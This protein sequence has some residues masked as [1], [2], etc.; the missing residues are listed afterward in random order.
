MDAF[1]DVVRWAD[2]EGVS[3]T[4]IAELAGVS[5]QTV[6]SMLRKETR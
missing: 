3:K 4:E 1:A 6:H 2:K 5:R